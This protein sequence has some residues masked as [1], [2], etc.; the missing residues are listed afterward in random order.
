MIRQQRNTTRR[1]EKSTEYEW[2]IE[3]EAGVDVERQ[4]DF[5]RGRGM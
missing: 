3:M 1:R 4:Q 5:I 2:K